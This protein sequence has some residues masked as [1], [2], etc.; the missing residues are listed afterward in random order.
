MVAVG[1]GWCTSNTCGDM[2]LGEAVENIKKRLVELSRW[3]V[4]E[5]A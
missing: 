2:A 5:D 4:M 3:G 1:P